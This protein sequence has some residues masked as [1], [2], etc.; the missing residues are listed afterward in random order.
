VLAL[1]LQSWTSW[2]F[3]HDEI[4]VSPDRCP[5]LASGALQTAE[6]A[7]RTEGVQ[8]LF[9]FV[10]I[11]TLVVALGGVLYTYGFSRRIG[12]P[13]VRRWWKMLGVSVAAASIVAVVMLL[14]FP[15]A[16]SGCEAGNG[17]ARVPGAWLA[18]R[19]L[20]AALHALVFYVLLSWLLTTILGRALKRGRWYDNHRVPFPALIPRR[21][22]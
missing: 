22:G 2:P 15:V 16:T 20:A 8:A 4:T 5:P 12:R 19:P 10:F 9:L 14:A 1:A 11:A 3:V 17:V 13:F 21:Q 7:L 18:L 6:A